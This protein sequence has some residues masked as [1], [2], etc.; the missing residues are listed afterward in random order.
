[1][2]TARSPSPL[3]RLTERLESVAFLDAPGKKVGKAARGALGPGAL[4]DAISGTWLGHPLHP[5]LTD[6]TLSCFV[7][8]S[9]LDVL[10]GDRDG[11][12]AQRLIAIGLAASGPTV[13]T[14]V[15][16]W[17]DTEIADERVRRVGVAHA[18][19]NTTAFVLFA[20][21]LAARRAGDRGRGKAL[22]L[23]GVGILAAGG[24]LGAHMSFFQGVGP[25]QTAFDQAPDDWTAVASSGDLQP[26]EPTS[27][28]AGDAP[29]LLLRHGDGLHALHDRCSHRGCALS[30][31]QVEG[32]LITCPCHGS[33]FD[34]RDGSLQ[35][36]PATA[37][38]PV[39]DV[40]EHDGRVE[41]RLRQAG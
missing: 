23:A 7:S 33:R 39:Y 24:Y 25:N 36:G 14:G 22:G 19:A 5:L 2:R 30:G 13:V 6:V 41:V 18:A 12:A 15:S 11:R 27:V 37:P 17:A 20:S 9:L 4:K 16:D 1:M 10:G 32:E 21:S 3:G 38:Q 35:R 40:R 26:G 28:V 31:G 8:A 29:V 34:V